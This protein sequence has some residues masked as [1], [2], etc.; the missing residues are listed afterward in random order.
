[1]DSIVNNGMKDIL[2]LIAVAVLKGEE[3]YEH[4]KINVVYVLTHLTVVNIL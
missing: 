1:M 4:K 3:I 2:H